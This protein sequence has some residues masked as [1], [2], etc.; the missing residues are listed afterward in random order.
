MDDGA[1]TRKVVITGVGVVSPAGIGKH[2]FW[3]T[4]RAGRPCIGEITRFDTSQLNIK[5]A[6]QI[7][8]FSPAS[9][10][11]L[12]IDENFHRVELY[13]ICAAK[14]ALEDS[15]ADLTHIKPE[16]IGVCLGTSAG[17]LEITVA[18]LL[19]R[20]Y[21]TFGEDESEFSLSDFSAVLP[22]NLS[23]QVAR[24]LRVKALCLGI[25]TGCTASADAIGCGYECIKS[26]MAD[27]MLVGG[28]EAPI[29]PVT[30]QAF[31]AIGTLS[32]RNDP[33]RSSRPFDRDRDGFVIAEGAAVL[34][35]E[36]EK[37]ALSR[38]AHFYAEVAGYQ[39]ACDAYHLTSSDPSMEASTRVIVSVLERAHI[40]R[41]QINYITAHGSST[42]MNDARETAIIKASLGDHA[43]R[44]PV[45][46]L[47]SMIGHTSG[48]AGAMQAVAL[49]LSMQHDFLLPT[50]N[51]ETPDA[52]CDLDYV[53]N[54]GRSAR[55]EYALQN[56][57][58][59]A[60]KNVAV[61]YKR[62]EDNRAV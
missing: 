61:L 14:L 53:P 36:E 55:I 46:G 56:T 57:Y 45:T 24:A 43:Y 49:A 2:Q 25:S 17:G 10:L 19:R 26:G 12:D 20:L 22:G 48:A 16:Q 59:Y 35:L 41:E 18:R 11:G 54:A 47:K 4:L 7:N 15:C 51:Y 37:H 58:A 30:I 33:E 5:I 62:P 40:E 34:L 1:E 31:D 6:G 8:G 9:Y 42:Q 52:E 27:F 60:G 23:A 13:A 38:G 29:E 3:N 39:T 21:P 28:S 44:V 50:I 32:H